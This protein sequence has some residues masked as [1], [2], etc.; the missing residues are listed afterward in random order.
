VRAL[1]QRVASASVAVDGREVSRIGPGMLVL[2]GVADSDA[3]E[4]ADRIVAKL[5]RLRIFE[6]ADGRTNEPLGEREIL[7]VS[8]FTL[9]ADVSKGNRPSFTGAAR[10][11]VARS[12]YE[13]VCEGLGA[14]RGEFGARMAVELVND[15]PFTLL[16]EA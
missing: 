11:E 10:P 14:E 8:Q 7:C 2:L 6:D 3:E 16:V 4:E 15:G 9:L 13:R 5:T 12:L 1:V